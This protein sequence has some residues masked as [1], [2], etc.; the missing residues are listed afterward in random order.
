VS[1]GHVRLQPA[2]FHEAGVAPALRAMIDCDIPIVAQ[3]DGVWACRCGASGCSKRGCLA[4]TR[5]WREAS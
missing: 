5:R 4:P 3:I 2:G 1:G